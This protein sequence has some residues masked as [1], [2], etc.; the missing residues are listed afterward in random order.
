MIRGERP[1]P[2]EYIVVSATP[3]G[4]DLPERVGAL[5]DLRALVHAHSGTVI[6]SWDTA[7][8]AIHVR[9]P[10][11]AAVAL[12]RIPWV[13]YVEENSSQFSAAQVATQPNPPN[14]GIDQLNLPLSAS[15][16][17]AFSGAGVHV[18]IV[19]SGISPTH[20]EFT[21]RLARNRAQCGW[22]R[23]AQCRLQTA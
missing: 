16:S 11:A 20:H 19:D 9:L 4:A 5:A 21:G 23:E 17:Y 12:S 18:Y 14:K 13:K 2:G 10:E 15:Y 3:H 6:Q 22:R 7:I 1:I 8:T